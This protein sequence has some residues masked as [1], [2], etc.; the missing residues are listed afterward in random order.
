MRSHNLKSLQSLETPQANRVSSCF[1]QNNPRRALDVVR[2]VRCV[3]YP[4]ACDARS[5]LKVRELEFSLCVQSWTRHRLSSAR[6]VRHTHAQHECRF[7]RMRTTEQWFLQH[8][9]RPR[10]ARVVTCNT[11]LRHYEDVKR[12]RVRGKKSCSHVMD[13]GADLI[14]VTYTLPHAITCIV[15]AR[16]RRARDSRDCLYQRVKR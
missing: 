9:D 8:L 15:S 12:T 6:C 10:R 2:R 13:A 5:R 4:C 7:Q 11:C 1:I 14:R 3:P 16:T